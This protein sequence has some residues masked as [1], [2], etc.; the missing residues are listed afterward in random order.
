MKK[1]FTLI[2]LLV[3]IAIIAILASMLLPA[4]AKAREKARSISCVNNLKQNDLALQMYADDWNG[5]FITHWWHTVPK[6]DGTKDGDPGISWC[7]A[8]MACKLLPWASKS[9]TCPAMTATPFLDTGRN[10]FIQVYGAPS[11][12][13][14]LK[15]SVYEQASDNCY[16]AIIASAVSNPS[17][18]IILADSLVKNSE[19]SFNQTQTIV[20]SSGNYNMHTRHADRA[21]VAMLDGHVESAL[22][23]QLKDYYKNQY[24]IS[25][26]TR[27]CLFVGLNA[28]TATSFNF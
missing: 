6:I 2:E 24:A 10:T 17:E 13:N 20:F 3:V 7:S 18:G 21:N 27:L 28:T 22:P 5:K 11:S 1:S 26:A 15:S 4:L 23:G 16:R 12:Y 9:I 8:L 25:T 14:C 19:T